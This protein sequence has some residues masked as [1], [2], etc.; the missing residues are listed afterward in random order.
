M[1]NMNNL[2]KQAQQMQLKINALQNELAT[3]ELDV[4][5]G[6]GA[7]KIRINGKQEILS[8]KIDRDCLDSGDLELLEDMLKESVNQAIA[9]SNKMVSDAMNKVT[10]GLKI[11]GM[12]F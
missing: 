6:G 11:P 4:S 7:I 10:G 9:D 3:R 12:N 1:K 5:T 2:L 8:I